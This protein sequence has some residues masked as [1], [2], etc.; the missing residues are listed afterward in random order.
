[1]EIG[2][3]AGPEA[4]QLEEHGR[5]LPLVGGREVA[6]GRVDTTAP[7]LK[8]GGGGDERERNSGKTQEKSE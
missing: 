6:R 2:H 5:D 7:N 3:Q 8:G 4:T 1:M